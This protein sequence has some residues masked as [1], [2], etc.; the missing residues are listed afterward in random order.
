MISLNVITFAEVLWATSTVKPH[1]V[2]T[3]KEEIK[4]LFNLISFFV[5]STAN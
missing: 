4:F 5:N 3:Q 2:Q 1:C